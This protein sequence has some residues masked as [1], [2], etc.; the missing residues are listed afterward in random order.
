MPQDGQPFVYFTKKNPLRV[1][2]QD[3]VAWTGK[4]VAK[5]GD[6][7]P[8]RFTLPVRKLSDVR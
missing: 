7:L 6:E 5:G 1:P 4:H 8:S 2:Q 3:P